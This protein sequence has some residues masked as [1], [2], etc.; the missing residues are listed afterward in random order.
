M[1]K[2]KNIGYRYLGFYRRNGLLRSFCR[3]IEA[4]QQKRSDSIY[5]TLY[6]K[7]M[8][9]RN[10]SFYNRER[11]NTREGDFKFS[12][13]VPAYDTEPE[14]LRMMIL[15][16]L[17]QTYKNLELIIADGSENAI[18]ENVVREFKDERIVYK[19]LEQNRGISENTNEALALATGKYLSFIDH[20]DF[21]ERDALMEVALA[22]RDGAE[23]I[24]TDEDKFD[25]D[26]N[27]YFCPNRKVDY[28]KDMFLSNNYICH[29]FTVSKKIADRAGGF[30]KE[31]D[32]AQD[33]DFILRCIEAAGEDKVKHIPK[34][35]YHWRTH[36]GSTAANP[37]SKKYAYESGRRVLE[38]Y[39]QRNNIAGSVEH[40]GHLG[41]YRINYINQTRDRDYKLYLDKR[42][43]PLNKDYENIMASY[44]SRKDIGAVGGRIIDSTGRIVSNGYV[45][46]GNGKVRGK[47][48]GMFRFFSGYMHRAEIVQDTQ[49]VASNACLIRAELAQYYSTDSYKCGEAIRK[50][51]YRI[52]VDPRVVFKIQS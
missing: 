14:Y 47:Y 30:R 33:Y 20:D 10:V 32:G 49:A 27:M 22:I 26:K 31:Y 29:L 51:G 19:R 7:K 17:R 25:G 48:C 2:I 18:V 1:G 46:D 3:F 34:V 4:L 42:L 13:I 28:N 23:V 36:S 9:K 37:A 44:L 38:D 45:R 8:S 52:I 16:V 39:L 5:N 11:R 24:Y 12:V 50:A 6:H 21:I 43:K 35:L 40:T 15:S 41:F